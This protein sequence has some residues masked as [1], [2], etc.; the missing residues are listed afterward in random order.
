MKKNKIALFSCAAFVAAGIG[1]N[2]QNAIADYGIAK[3]SLSLVAVGPGSNSG[4]N[5]N[6]NSNSN[7]DT[8]PNISDSDSDGLGN[9][10][11][12]Y[13]ADYPACSGTVYFG[14]KG[15]TMKYH[16]KYYNHDPQSYTFDE[17]EQVTIVPR[18][19]NA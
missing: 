4:P 13:L 3:N 2:I 15:T 18:E 9:D 10:E 11:G 19:K 14:K 6:S 8:S 5:S 17:T 16:F 1:L 7:T 12:N